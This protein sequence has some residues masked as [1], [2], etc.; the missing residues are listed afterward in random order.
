M[1]IFLIVVFSLATVVLLVKNIKL[2]KEL[3]ASD[4]IAVAFAKRNAK[5]NKEWEQRVENIEMEH[6]MEMI[7]LK[8]KYYDNMMQLKKEHS[9]EIQRLKNLLDENNINS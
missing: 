9:E 2:E 3:N 4:E 1:E 6:G 5:L 8:S 7:K